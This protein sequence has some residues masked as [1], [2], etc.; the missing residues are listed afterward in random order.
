[1]QVATI[2]RS[3]GECKRDEL[4]NIR[5]DDIKK[6]YNY[7]DKDRKKPMVRVQIRNPNPEKQRDFTLEGEFYNY[8]EKY[9]QCR[10]QKENTSKEFFLNYRDGKCTRQPIG[11]NKFGRM[12]KEIA[13]FLELPNPDEYTGH[14]KSSAKLHSE[15]GLVTTT[16]PTD[17]IECDDN[18]TNT[19]SDTPKQ[20]VAPS[21][22]NFKRKLCN[23]ITSSINLKRPALDKN[24]I[25]QP[26]QKPPETEQQTSSSSSTT[27]KTY[28]FAGQQ[29]PDTAVDITSPG[30]TFTLRISN[31]SNC[32]FNFIEKKAD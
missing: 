18:N 23:Q 12:P 10:C 14:S 30:G 15:D 3:F 4:K 20:Y 32:T 5:L 28:V 7:D 1:M 22:A 31:C 13:Q 8:Y 27:T 17:L 19:T 16:L 21:P 2:F 11:L 9:R 24:T 29:N 6:Y 25:C 26:P